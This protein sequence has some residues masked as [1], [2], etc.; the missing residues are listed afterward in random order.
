MSTHVRSSICFQEKLD[1]VLESKA[2]YN[3][4]MEQKKETFV[5][6]KVKEKRMKER[7]ERDKE[8]EK[9]EKKREAEK[10]D[11]Y[12]PCREKTCLWGRS[13][14]TKTSLLSYRY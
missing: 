7:E 10:V 1:K 8:R 3:A 6:D 5:K 11:I 2:S 4:W 14:L 13:S 9:L 12:G